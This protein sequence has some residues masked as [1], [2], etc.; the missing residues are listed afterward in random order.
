[1]MSQFFHISTFIERLQKCRKNS[2]SSC[3]VMIICFRRFFFNLMDIIIILS[4][5]FMNEN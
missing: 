2:Y 4:Q 3:T 5:Q 1:M